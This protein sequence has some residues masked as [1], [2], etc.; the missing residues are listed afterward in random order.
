MLGVFWAG[1]LSGV[2]TAAGRVT[3]W[4]CSA[5]FYSERSGAG[6]VRGGFKAVRPDASAPTT[7]FLLRVA[8]ADA[9][10]A[11]SSTWL[12]RGRPTAG[13]GWLVVAGVAFLAAVVPALRF[14]GMAPSAKLAK[15]ATK[16]VSQ[17]PRWKQW[18]NQLSRDPFS[19]IES[20]ILWFFEFFL[21]KRASLLRPEMAFIRFDFC[22]GFKRSAGITIL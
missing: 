2:C 1:V 18:R 16:R 9:P 6:A 11:C 10:G 20:W 5:V 3:C 8:V 4:L 21:K 7:P 13:V 14:F 12:E 17:A 22:S 19:W 15:K